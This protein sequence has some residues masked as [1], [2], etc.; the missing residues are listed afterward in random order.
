MTTASFEELLEW[1]KTQGLKFHPG[2]QR[3][4]VNGIPGLYA[5]RDIPARSILAQFPDKNLFPLDSKF[6]YPKG[7][8]FGFAY[9]HGIARELAKGDSGWF[10]TRNFYEIDSLK[11]HHSYFYTE[12]EL[13]ELRKMNHLLYDYTVR[14]NRETNFCIQAICRIDNSMDNPECRQH[15]LKT[16][17]NHNMRAWGAGIGFIPGLDMFNHSDVKGCMLVRSQGLNAIVAPEAIKEGEQIWLSYGKK[18]IHLHAINYG[19]FDPMGSHCI[20]LGYRFSQLANNDFQRKVFHYV[21]KKYPVTFETDAQQQITYKLAPAAAF[22]LENAPNVYA[23]DF[24]RDVSFRNEMELSK[25]IYIPHRFRTRM[26]Q[27]V[28]A[29]LE[30]NKVDAVDINQVPEKLQYFHHMLQREKQILFRN[31]HWLLENAGPEAPTQVIPLA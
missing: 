10:P 19:Y 9:V 26:L 30:S 6:N 15:L 23:I 21:K 14:H 3:K 17:I 2:V 24:F 20:D 13:S 1:G 5:N 4:I 12:E 27:Y 22:L 8:T 11:T 18:D 29:L 16:L 28:D 25:K 7:V 31:K